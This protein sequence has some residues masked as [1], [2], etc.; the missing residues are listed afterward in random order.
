MT[1]PIAGEVAAPIR[2]TSTVFTAVALGIIAAIVS[3][4]RLL[5]ANDTVLATMV[6]AEDGLFPLCARAQGFWPC[7]VEPY[8]GYVLFLPRVVAWPVSWFPL[9]N[10]PLVT[11]IAAAV[12]AGVASALGYLVLRMSGVGRVASGLVALLP[13]LL[14]IMAF[15]AINVTGSSY[16]LLVFV[17]TLALCFPARPRFPTWAYAIGLFVTT[18]TIPSSAVLLLPLGVQARRKRIA[19]RSG[20]IVGGALVLGLG[21]QLWAAMTADNPRQ[22][23]FS[24]DA[25]LAWANGVPAS[26]LSFV[27]GQVALS[28]TGTFTAAEISI[29]SVVGV[30]LVVALLGLGVALTIAKGETAN[31]VGLLLVV[32]LMMGLLP[33]A[34][35][36]A[37]NRYFVIPLLL[38]TAAVVIAIDRW[39]PARRE[40]VMVVVALLL[41]ALCI[42]SLEASE[43]RST[44]VPEW[45]VMLEAA[46]RT[47][48]ANPE[49]MTAVTFS[50]SWPFVDAVFRGPT[51]NVVLCSVVV[52]TG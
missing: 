41:V 32:G 35:G 50:P 42:P 39:I 43:T 12:I 34:A 48:A 30:A 10:W 33:A 11:N 38:W 44:S 1:R 14:P 18:L 13:A 47:C 2:L 25:L 49:G 19:L 45:D 23:A 20:L 27:P 37:N 26:L 28:G 9:D 15:E 29:P 5:L 17:A 21:V 16:M 7:M 52:D 8:S 46:R 40:L 6:W 36:F 4:T 24:A 3:L 22:I 51:N 31:G